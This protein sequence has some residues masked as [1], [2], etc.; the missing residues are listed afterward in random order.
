LLAPTANLPQY[1]P[2]PQYAGLPSEETMQVN[3]Y[4]VKASKLWCAYLTNET[5][6]QIGNAEFAPTKELAGFWL[7]VQY[8]NLRDR[9][10]ND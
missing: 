2:I 1:L 6:D 3:C 9:Q 4:Y 8:A 5:D 7:G 10:T